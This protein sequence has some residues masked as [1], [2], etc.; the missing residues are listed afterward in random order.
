MSDT[1]T[2]RPAE[3]AK[4][5]HPGGRPLADAGEPVP[6]N[7]YWS[8]R[9]SA[10]DVVDISAGSEATEPPASIESTAPTPVAATSTAKGTR[11][12][13]EGSSDDH[14]L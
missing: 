13:T 9:L 1:K 10:G 7:A 12:Q 14:Q 3:G 5:R 4:V 11:K 2:L 6:M 8:R